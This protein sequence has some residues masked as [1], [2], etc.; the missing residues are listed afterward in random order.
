MEGEGVNLLFVHKIS[1]EN[2]IKLARNKLKY[3]STLK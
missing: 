2:K 1:D 3:K